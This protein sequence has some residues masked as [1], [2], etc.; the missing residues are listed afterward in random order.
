MEDAARNDEAVDLELTFENED[1]LTGSFQITSFE[2][3]GEATEAQIYSMS[4]ES[5]SISAMSRKL[6]PYADVVMALGPE[7]Y[8]KLDELVGT[9]LADSSGNGHGAVKQSGTLGQDPLINVG[10]SMLFDGVSNI[11]AYALTSPGDVWDQPGAGGFTVEAWIHP[12]AAATGGGKSWV[13]ALSQYPNNTA[14]T[15]WYLGGDDIDGILSWRF[16]LF[17]DNGV[18]RSS[19]RQAAAL[20]LNQRYHLVGTVQPDGATEIFVNGASAGTGPAN[21]IPTPVTGS[22]LLQIGSVFGYPYHGTF[23]GLSGRLDEPLI[24]DY[25]LTPAQVLT[26]YNAGIQ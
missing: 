23:K 4:L 7:A 25:P 20:T 13:P 8:W 5:K 11:I 15:R 24:Y 17:D 12:T 9:D 22:H 3:Q 16:A 1:K 21:G 10:N 2:Y 19:A 14:Q 26:N 6:P 18:L